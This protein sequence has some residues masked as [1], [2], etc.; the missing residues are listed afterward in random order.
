MSYALEELRKQIFTITTLKTKHFKMSRV[1]EF[2]EL[3]KNEKECFFNIFEILKGTTGY[4]FGSKV[5]KKIY[6]N[7][8]YVHCFTIHIISF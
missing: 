4:V 6:I 3:V 2:L 1:Q 8:R 5:K 7:T